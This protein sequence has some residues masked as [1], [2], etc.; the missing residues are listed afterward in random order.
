[1]DLLE[2]G[3]FCVAG[4]KRGDYDATPPLRPLFRTLELV[5][6][7]SLPAQI[8]SMYG[9][10]W[11]PAHEAAYRSAVAGSRARVRGSVAY[12]PAR[13]ALSRS[14]AGPGPELGSTFPC[15]P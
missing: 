12:G 13:V 8:R 11:T 9:F 10:R 4:V 6:K 7:G 3:R 2:L 5:V 14:Y 15:R 1:M